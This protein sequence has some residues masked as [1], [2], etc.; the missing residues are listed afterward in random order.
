MTNRIVATV[1]DGTI[2][3]LPDGDVLTD[4]EDNL[5]V[6][7]I[8]GG[9]QASFIYPTVTKNLSDLNCN[10]S[11]ADEEQWILPRAGKL[12]GIAAE[13]NGALTAGTVTLDIYINDVKVT[14]G[15]LNGLVL[16]SSNQRAYATASAVVS[17]SAGDRLSLHITTGASI[18]PETLDMHYTAWY[19]FS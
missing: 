5:I 19:L 7:N 3:P 14:T 18:D 16:D 1:I 15:G 2:K 8:N 4:E 12:T 6:T 17:F 11:G 9:G 13:M 10:I